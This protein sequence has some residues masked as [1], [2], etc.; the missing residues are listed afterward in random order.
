[1]TVPEALADPRLRRYPLRRLRLPVAGGQLSIVTPD[2]AAWRR[3]GGGVDRILR[4]EEP[5]YWADIWPAS[6]VAARILCRH[7][8]LGGLRVFDLG[9]GIGVAGSAAAL[10]GA[11]VCFA[12]REP[13]ALAFALFNGEHNCRQGGSVRGHPFDWS[14]D[15]PPPA[16]DLWLLCDL[17]YRPRYHDSLLRQLTG[18]LGHGALALHC[19]PMRVES[20]SFLRR[21]AQSFAVHTETVPLAAEG[22]T[23]HMRITLLAH[24]ASVLQ[25]WLPHLRPR[26]RVPGLESHA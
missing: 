7:G 25:P 16:M 5:P 15:A 3:R 1:V 24:A 23:G 21:L 13:D 11:E 17:S 12:D 26:R 19:D 14:T 4:G 6:L 2:T 10:C 9:C 18:G 22:Q 20:E 8:R